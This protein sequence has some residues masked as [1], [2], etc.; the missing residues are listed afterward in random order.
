[1]NGSFEPKVTVF[2]NATNVSFDT[3][4]D[5]IL[6]IANPRGAMG[7]QSACY[8]SCASRMFMLENP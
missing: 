3:S 6:A 8:I 5:Q 1:M 2:C 4:V 7:V